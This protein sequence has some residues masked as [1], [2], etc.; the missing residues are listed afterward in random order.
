[1]LL[2]TTVAGIAHRGHASSPRAFN[3]FIDDFLLFMIV[4]IAPWVAI[5]LVD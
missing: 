3:T 5:F 2:D 4:W 1:M